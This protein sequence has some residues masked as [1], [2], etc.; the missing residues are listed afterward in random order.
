MKKAKP[1]LILP[2]TAQ[3]V[4]LRTDPLCNAKIRKQTIRNLKL[5]KNCNKEEI[6]DRI[7]DLNLEWDT[8]RFMEAN[9]A[10]LIVLISYLGIKTGKYWFFATA[11]VGISLLLHALQ[12]WCPFLP[13]IRKRGIRTENE[14]NNERT[15]LKI[16]RKDFDGKYSTAEELLDTVEKQ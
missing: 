7:R 12:G 3:R 15:A 11:M 4:F 5:Y 10:V 14:I 6:T 2:P 8:E 13:F 9:A 16:L 1:K